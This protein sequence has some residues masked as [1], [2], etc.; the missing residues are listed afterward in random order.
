MDEIKYYKDCVKYALHQRGIAENDFENSGLRF[1]R[2]KVAN[3]QTML[4]TLKKGG[5]IIPTVSSS[6][7]GINDCEQTAVVLEYASDDMQSVIVYNPIV[8]REEV[9]PFDSF[10]KAWTEAGGG[11]TTA[12]E[13][14]GSYKPKLIDLT[15]VELPS[16]L[17]DLCEAIAENA[18]DTWALER[19]SEG[20]TWG[21]ERDDE[22]LQTPDMV[23]YAE[24]PDSE[25]Q[26]DRIVAFDTLK[27]LT[28]LGYKICKAENQFTGNI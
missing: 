8:E 6:I 15:H 14:D 7:F 3:P 23:P 9:Y 28:A 27:L 18:H 12:F 17:D 21:P 25:K 2:R 16:D 22:N 5:I 20:W 24:L 19:Q 10:V 4:K 11:C 1:Y 13:E 26:Y